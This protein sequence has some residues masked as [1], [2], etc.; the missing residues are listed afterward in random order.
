[1]EA[2]TIAPL[3]CD[4]YVHRFTRSKPSSNLST[5]SSSSVES[6]SLRCVILVGSPQKMPHN[7]HIIVRTILCFPPSLHIAPPPDRVSHW[8]MG[9]QSPCAPV[10][11][12]LIVGEVVDMLEFKHPKA[13]ALHQLLAITELFDKANID[14][15][16]S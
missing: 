11:R 10:Q 5:T 8:L 2:I 9:S 7:T 12:H 15:V 6:Q 14:C 16:E 1:M 4:S 3:M 13:L